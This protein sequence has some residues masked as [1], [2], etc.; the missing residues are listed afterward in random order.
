MNT[1][2]VLVSVG[3]RPEAV[4][5]APVVHELARRDRFRVRVLATAQHRAL[6]DQIL[7]FFEVQPHIDLDLMREDQSLADLTS[8][9]VS[10][11]DAALDA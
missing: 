5:L 4:K 9:M 3:T 7:G 6:L 1:A 10:A 8:R 11:V 2:T